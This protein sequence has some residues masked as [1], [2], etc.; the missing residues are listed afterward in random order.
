MDAVQVLSGT[1]RDLVRTG[2][3]AGMRARGDVTGKLLDPAMFTDPYPTYDSLRGNAIVR[4]DLGLVTTRHSLSS[5]GLRHPAMT[6]AMAHRDEMAAA[7]PRFMQWLFSTP[8]RRGLIDPLG[9]ESMIGSTGPS[10]PGCASSS[11]RCSP[12]Q[13]WSSCG[14]ASRASLTSCSSRPERSRC[15]M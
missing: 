14:P 12:R 4:T 6:S 1:V 11:A 9:A 15:S 13:A 2:V 10:T 8:D 3:V 5:A 7:S